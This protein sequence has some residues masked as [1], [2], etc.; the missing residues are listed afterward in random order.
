MKRI[1]TYL[2]NGKSGLQSHNL[3]YVQF[4]Q[5]SPVFLPSALPQWTG[6]SLLLTLVNLGK[7]VSVPVK[8]MKCEI[9]IHFIYRIYSIKRPPRINAHLVGRKS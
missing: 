7:V 6:E 2:I 3:I 5:H 8:E 9:M 1:G 4:S